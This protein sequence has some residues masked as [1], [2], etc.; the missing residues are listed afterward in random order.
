MSKKTAPR[1]TR[2]IAEFNGK[3]GFISIRPMDK[4][5]II[6]TVAFCI[7]V[8]IDSLA[9]T[10]AP[11]FILL[12]RNLHFHLS[13][14]TLLVSTALFILALYIGLARHADVTPYFRRGVY[15]MVG[16]MLFEALIGGMMF[17]QGLRPAEDVHVIYGAATVLALPFFIFVEITAE[18]RP[19]MGS[20]MWG[21]AL[22]A[23]I[24]IRCINTGAV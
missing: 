15:I 22:L 1:A 8:I 17:L 23:G 20:Y 7:L 6:G 9:T 14:Y 5:L 10:P 12:L 19:A 11:P 4:A 16:V 18:K 24:I 13:R 3:I 2:R 21:F